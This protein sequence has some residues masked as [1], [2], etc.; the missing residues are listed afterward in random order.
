MTGFSVGVPGQQVAL[1]CLGLMGFSTVSFS[2]IVSP[3]I[4][5]YGM[6]ARL[7]SGFAA[8]SQRK[9][10]TGSKLDKHALPAVH[11]ELVTLKLPLGV[12]VCVL[13]YVPPV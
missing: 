5:D 1:Q 4:L 12:T 2:L 11:R 7:L 3:F 9:R 13:L 10:V 8:S 6:V